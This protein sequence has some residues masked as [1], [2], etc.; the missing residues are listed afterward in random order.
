M[1][2][3][4]KEVQE[5]LYSKDLF[6]EEMKQLD[7]E[8]KEIDALYGEIKTHYDTIKNA[9]F[10]GS[11]VFLKD[12]TSNLISLKTAKL[13]YIKQKADLKKTI[14]DY[15]FK[16]KASNKQ[17]TEVD[18]LTEAIY[19]KITSEFGYVTDKESEPHVNEVDNIDTLLDEELENEDI[20]NIIGSSV[21]IETV[22]VDYETGEVTEDENDE[23]N[24][25]ENVVDSEPEVD[26]TNANTVIAVDMDTNTFYQIDE[27]TFEIVEELGTMEDKIVDEVE[28]ENDLYAIG[29]SGNMYLVISFDEE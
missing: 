5:N 7:S 27:K 22:E 13:S 29:E 16:E 8:L 17:D 20:G 19:K 3:K 21:S 9:Q 11:L 4:N 24:N 14:T 25:I 6:E 2:E 10:K 18:T 26:E 15:A 28:I 23:E 12:Q 1:D